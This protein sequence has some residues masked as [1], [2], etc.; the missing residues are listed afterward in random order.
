MYQYKNEY[1]VRCFIMTSYN[2]VYVDVYVHIRYIGIGSCER[3]N[4]T[5][6]FT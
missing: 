4:I 5:G 2:A 6:I 1:I 3:E